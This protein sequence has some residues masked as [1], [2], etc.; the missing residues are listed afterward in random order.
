MF[1]FISY[2]REDEKWAKWLQRKLES[3]KLPAIIRK[4]NP[5]L[6]QRI[7]PVFRDKTDMEAGLITDNLRNE[8]E[9]SKYLIVICSPKAAKSDWVGQ[10]Q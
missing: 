2:N 7:Y 10:G 3:Y 4:E 9:T 6:P 8:P 5:N 1:H